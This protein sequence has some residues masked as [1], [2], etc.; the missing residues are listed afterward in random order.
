MKLHWLLLLNVYHLL[1]S[2]LS[3]FYFTFW[4]L[5][6][7]LCLLTFTYTLIYHILGTFFFLFNRMH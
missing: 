6:C 4:V 2:V 3:N 5:F 7:F 1:V